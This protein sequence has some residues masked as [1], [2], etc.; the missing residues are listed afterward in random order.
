M[1]IL[2]MMTANLIGFAI[3][4]DGMAYM[5]SQMIGTWAGKSSIPRSESE[6]TVE[7]NVLFTIYDRDSIY[8][9]CFFYIV[10]SNALN[11]RI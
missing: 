6:K 5:W 9:D 7:L 10:C 1:N 11:V 4:T 3:G 8:G 2:L